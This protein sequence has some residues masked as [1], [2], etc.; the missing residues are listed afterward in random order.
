MKNNPRAKKIYGKGFWGIGINKTSRGIMPDS[1]T[2]PF[3]LVVTLKAIDNVNRIEDFVQ[4]CFL[5]NWL[6]RRL[7]VNTQL[8]VYN[9]ADTEIDWE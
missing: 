5:N 7:D 8:D 4:Q 6:V 3:G 1:T 9:R 2:I